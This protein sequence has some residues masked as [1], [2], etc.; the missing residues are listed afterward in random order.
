[1]NELPHWLH[2]VDNGTIGEAR[3]RAMLINRFWILERSVDIEGADFL[4]QRKIWGRNLL[5]ERAPCL[6]YVQSK[7]CQNE[8]TPVRVPSDY[9]LDANESPRSEFFLFVQSGEPGYELTF[10]LT[11]RDIAAN[12]RKASDAFLSS[13]SDIKALPDA[14]VRSPKHV[15]S[16]IDSSLSQADFRKN[17]LFYRYLTR[18]SGDAE[19]PVDYDF[20][21]P[22]SNNWGDI[23]ENFR[24]VRTRTQQLIDD[25]ESDIKTLRNALSF[26]D[27]IEF[28]ETFA[29]EH[30]YFLE[31][32]FYRND[33]FFDDDFYHAVVSHKKRVDLL[34]SRDMLQAFILLK[35]RVAR[36]LAD[37]LPKYNHSDAPFVCIDVSI[38]HASLDIQSISD[39]ECLE[40]AVYRTGR[41]GRRDTD[42]PL[43]VLPQGHT[44][45][46]YFRRDSLF[47]SAD[48]ISRYQRYVIDRFDIA[49]LEQL[50]GEDEI[51][52]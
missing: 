28:V 51:H 30:F 6:G 27:P 18:E 48:T 3:T 44:Y 37:R 7:F 24:E 31:D 41:P 17:R 9:V 21:L 32:Y 22:L 29:Y 33:A 16:E 34:R 46:I 52:A 15:L 13:L 12:F 40:G 19:F 35:T 4:I 50:F 25:L 45:T 5:D 38:D 36:E 43:G 47:S 23:V 2:S 42:W 49:V 11:A 14:L 8:T 1:M 20:T 26:T 10:F 39:Y